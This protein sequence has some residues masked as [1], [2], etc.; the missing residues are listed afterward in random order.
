MNAKTRILV[1]D[2]ASYNQDSAQETL[3]NHDLTII[4]TIEEAWKTNTALMEEKIT[5]FDVILTDLWMPA[6]K[7]HRW[8]AGSNTLDFLGCPY[9]RPDGMVGDQIPAGLIFALLS[10]RN[11]IPVGIVTDSNHHQDRLVRMLDLVMRRPHDKKPFNRVAMFEARYC[12]VKGKAWNSRTETVVPSDDQW[13]SQVNP[14]LRIIKD[15]GRVL[16]SIVRN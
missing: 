12:F 16:N 2:D 1:I 6:P 15:W 8:T 14:D 13:M 3:G 4:G 7:M 9:E 10:M 11:G 5:P